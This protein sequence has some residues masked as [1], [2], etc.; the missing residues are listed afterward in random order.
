MTSSHALPDQI[1]FI[2]IIFDDLPLGTQYALGAY[3]MY[4]SSTK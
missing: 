4:S 3:Q 2:H 1:L